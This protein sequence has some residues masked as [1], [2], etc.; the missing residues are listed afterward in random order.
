MTIATMASFVDPQPIAADLA[1]I[2][3][4]TDTGDRTALEAAL[5]PHLDAGWRLARRMTTSTANAEDILQEA[6]MRAVKKAHQYRGTGSLRSWFLGIVANAGRMRQRGEQRRQLRQPA[7]HVPAE[8]VTDPE[9]LGERALA[10]LEKIPQHERTAVWLHVVEEL[11]YSEISS[12]LKR[13]EV[14]VRS[15]VSRGLERL[16]EALSGR[17]MAVS[18]ASLMAVLAAARAESAPTTVITS[19]LGT[20]ATAPIAAAKAGLLLAAAAVLS[21]GTATFFIALRERPQP[22][23]AAAVEENQPQVEVVPSSDG[24]RVLGQ[25]PFMATTRISDIQLSPDGIRLVMSLYVNNGTTLGF[26]AEVWSTVDGTRQWTLPG[27]EPRWLG[28]GTL[29]VAVDKVEKTAHIGVGE[30]NAIEIWDVPAKKLLRTIDLGS[31]KIRTLTVAPDGKTIFA[32]WEPRWDIRDNGKSDRGYDNLLSVDTS[33]GKVL[34]SVDNIARQAA[35]N[36]YWIQSIGVTDDASRLVFLDSWAGGS[37]SSSRDLSVHA[38]VI[39]W[40]AGQ[41]VAEWTLSIA[42]SPQAFWSKKTGALVITGLPG[43]EK[44]IRT[45]LVDPSSGSIKFEW[46]GFAAADKDGSLLIA[47]AEELN[48]IDPATGLSEKVCSLH[49]A[50][51]GWLRQTQASG[52]WFTI[53]NYT[54]VP[55]LVNVRERRQV[56]PALSGHSSLPAK[57]CY[58]PDGTL[59]VAGHDQAYFYRTNGERREANVRAG[60]LSQIA[61]ER[62]LLTTTRITGRDLTQPVI[63]DLATG[64]ELLRLPP[65]SYIDSMWL[66]DDAT[67]AA[68]EGQYDGSLHLYELPSG[69]LLAA[70]SGAG[71]TEDDFGPSRVAI[72]GL[73]WSKDLKRIFVADGARHISRLN[74][75]A[76]TENVPQPHSLTGIRDARTGELL[77]AFTNA[78]G[79]PIDQA[80]TLDVAEDADL[81]YLAYAKMKK[82]P[83]GDRTIDQPDG[84]AAGFWRASDGTFVRSLELPEASSELRFNYDGSLLVGGSGAVSVADGKVV[85]SYAIGSRSVSATGTLHGAVAADG[86][87]IISDLRDGIELTRRVCIVKGSGAK[88]GWPIWSQ[89]ER[90]VAVC[91][92][93]SAVVAQIDL[94][95]APGPDAPIDDFEADDLTRRSAA[96][97]AVARAGA[98]GLR[99]LRTRLDWSK[100]SATRGTRAAIQALDA[101]AQQEIAGAADFLREGTKSIEPTVA[102]WA[103]EAVL[104]V[105]AGLKASAVSRAWGKDPQPLEWA[106]QQ[107]RDGK[108]SEF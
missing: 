73:K 82:V 5:R 43:H 22:A 40:P 64:T 66:S 101:L 16:R 13:R 91:F 88:P 14:T 6:C 106:T 71:M 63:N 7:P 1:L 76:T 11:S 70:L 39:S 34:A 93:D 15:Q 50:G 30:S 86:S 79:T 100:I 21:V 87:L 44:E 55:V 27:N 33:S 35:D 57:V 102:R 74:S 20:L 58:L 61:V 98:D 25:T 68:V 97:D 56:A 36:Y 41:R 95:G 60:A 67:L 94:A 45:T 37:G 53:G 51:E 62:V 85:R 107:R 46:P 54:N 89:G 84:I 47:T 18:S 8:E 29:A 59:S 10:Q 9:G 48:R 12:A 3:R 52:D 19:S 24:V 108:G 72:H 49:N 80:L 78:D 69:N 31:K 96:I 26:F 105:E 75:G 28:D 17:G 92:S 38:C 104:R 4:W 103:K 83:F 23:P 2:R 90:Q 99:S 77:H 32:A 65:R 81:V 42:N